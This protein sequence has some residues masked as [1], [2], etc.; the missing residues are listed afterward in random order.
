MKTFNEVVLS[1]V[2]SPPKEILYGI[3]I[4]FLTKVGRFMTFSSVTRGHVTSYTTETNTY[5]REILRISDRLR[6]TPRKEINMARYSENFIGH[7]I[8]ANHIQI[9]KFECF[10]FQGIFERLIFLKKF[11][12]TYIHHKS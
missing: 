5:G 6:V 12:V 7:V 10:K 3:F 8:T 1:Y 4:I 11:K 9:E 2:R